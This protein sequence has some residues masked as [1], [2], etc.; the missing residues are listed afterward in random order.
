MIR[1]SSGMSV[2]QHR[3]A[4]RWVDQHLAV[5]GLRQRTRLLEQ[6]AAHGDLAEVVEEGGA[7]QPHDL[8]LG[9]PHLL[10]D[11]D[12]VG[13]HVLGVVARVEVLSIDGRDERVEVRE[14][15]CLVRAPIDHH[16]G[17]NGAHVLPVA[18]GPVESRVGLGLELLDRAG[19]VGA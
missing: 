8:L 7:A 2:H 19:V 16:L 4:H 13:R 3:T 1:A 17:R 15:P 10:A 9:E 11:R 18:L 6:A 14:H 12:R 5:L